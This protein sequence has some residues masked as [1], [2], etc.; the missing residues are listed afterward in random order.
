MN[1]TTFVPVRQMHVCDCKCVCCSLHFY[2]DGM[3]DTMRTHKRWC[4][5]GMAILSH[6]CRFHLEW[7][8]DI[9]TFLSLHLPLCLSPS[10]PFF[11][12]LASHITPTPF[13]SPSLYPCILKTLQKQLWEKKKSEVKG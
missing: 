11:L 3:S 2:G 12:S 1:K 9:S 7:I 4:D 10:P 6:P 5:V 8:R 13:I